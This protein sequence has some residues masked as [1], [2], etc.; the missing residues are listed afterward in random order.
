MN[1]QN[2]RDCEKRSPAPLDGKVQD[3][4]TDQ[5]I[6]HLFTSGKAAVRL[7]PRRFSLIDY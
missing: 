7:K 6:P 5:P 2:D 1:L 3:V 4:E